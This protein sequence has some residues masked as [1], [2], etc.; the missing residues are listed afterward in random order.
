[1]TN[2]ATTSTIGGTT[3]IT[4]NTNTGGIALAVDYTQYF[5]IIAKTLTTLTNTMIAIQT[6]LAKI[7]SN[8]AAYT[9]LGEGDGIHWRS[10][11]QWKGGKASYSSQ[12]TENGRASTGTTI[13]TLRNV[14]E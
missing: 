14:S 10:P 3:I 9:K 13:V 12:V 2:T 8:I 11:E 6:D 1:M 7:S 4:V 5:E